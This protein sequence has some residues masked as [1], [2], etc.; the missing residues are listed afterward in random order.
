LNHNSLE[1]SAR[2]EHLQSNRVVDPVERVL[3]A[4]RVEKRVGRSCDLHG[5]LRL[6]L[7][8]SAARTCSDNAHS[9]NESEQGTPQPHEFDCYRPSLA[10]VGATLTANSPLT[11]GHSFHLGGVPGSWR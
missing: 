6:R 10:S 2:F 9:Q 5:R 8:V 11:P 3:F 7:T 1:D 4:G